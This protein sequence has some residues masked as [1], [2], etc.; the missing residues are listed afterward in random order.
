M[1][2]IIFIPSK[3][4][5]INDLMVFTIDTITNDIMFS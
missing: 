5:N 2:L 3:Q 4:L 1:T